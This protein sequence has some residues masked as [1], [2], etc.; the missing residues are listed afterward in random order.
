VDADDHARARDLTDMTVKGPGSR[1]S[2]Y[3]RRLALDPSPSE[4]RLHPRRRFFLPNATA[5]T[6]A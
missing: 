6:R 2:R 5:L 1:R 3:S 4:Q